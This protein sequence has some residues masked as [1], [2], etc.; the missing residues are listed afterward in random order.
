MLVL[1][2]DV[3]QQ[4]RNRTQSSFN[5]AQFGGD[6]F[7]LSNPGGQKWVVDRIVEAL[8]KV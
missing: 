7:Y 6:H 2:L 3:H 5:C 4:R 8:D 1:R